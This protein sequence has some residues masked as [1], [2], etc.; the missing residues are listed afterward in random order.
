MCMFADLL[1]INEFGGVH[2]AYLKQGT[3]STFSENG[4]IPCQSYH[5]KLVSCISDGASVNT[6]TDGGLM[7]RLSRDSHHLWVVWIHC[8]N[9]NVE[10]A[11]KDELKES[12]FKEVGKMYQT[13]FYLCQNTE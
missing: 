11:V 9:L 4:P 12:I 5:E 6:G 10:F 2:A 1:Q 13:L 3:F 8:V 7:V